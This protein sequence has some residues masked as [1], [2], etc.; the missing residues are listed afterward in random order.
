M[1]PLRLVGGYVDEEP[2]L[3]VVV[4]LSYPAW[5]QGGHSR[6]YLMLELLHRRVLRLRLVTVGDGG[7]R[8]AVASGGIRRSAILA[9]VTAIGPLRITAATVVG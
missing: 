8:G 6:G 4:V 3:S 5:G 2:A 1:L 9:A 7:R